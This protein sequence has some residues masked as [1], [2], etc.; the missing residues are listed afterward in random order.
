MAGRGMREIKRRIRSVKSSEQITRA[1]EMVSAAKLRRNQERI[2]SARPFA[3]KMEEIMMRLLAV[4]GDWYQNP[5][6][7]KRDVKRVACIV[8]TGDRGLCGAYNA[9]V[10]RRSVS[11]LKEQRGRETAVIPVGRKGR[12]F[13]RKRDFTLA[14][15]F[16]GL[17]EEPDVTDARNIAGTAIT[18]FL[19]GEVDEVYL[20]YTEFVSALQQKPVTIKLLPVQVNKEARSGVLGEYIYE[21]SEDALLDALVPRLVETEVYRALLESKASEEGARMAAMGAATDNAQEII[22]NLTLT[23]NR[24]RQ[25]AITTEI[26]EIVSGA[27][28]LRG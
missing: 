3:R 10:I 21:P 25:A 23:Y 6:L 12:D 27:E 5:L 7:E 20:V 17:G 11:L 2:F 14:T 26:I 8:I 15:E 13:F 4:A 16:L 9:G 24:A 28:A 1:M 22:Q 18:S 19:S